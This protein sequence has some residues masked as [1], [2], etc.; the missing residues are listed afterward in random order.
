MDYQRHGLFNDLRLEVIVR[1][2]DIGGMD[3]HHC[4]KFLFIIL[5]PPDKFQGAYSFY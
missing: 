2:V 1:F 5:F 4:L 3:D